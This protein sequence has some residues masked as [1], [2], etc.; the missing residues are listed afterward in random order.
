ME[1]RVEQLERSTEE[2]KHTVLAWS[3]MRIRAPGT[4]SREVAKVGARRRCM[5]SGTCTLSCGDLK[6]A[7]TRPWT[8]RCRLPIENWRG[9]RRR[10][11]CAR[12]AGG[13]CRRGAA[14]AKAMRCFQ[15]RPWM[16]RYRLPI[17]NWRVTRHRRPCARA[18]GRLCR[19]GAA[20]ARAR[21][22]EFFS[23]S[24]FNLWVAVVGN[25]LV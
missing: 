14:G 17:E 22:G 5:S 4:S 7:P 10:R 9:S 12:A 8:R 24:Y 11:S 1:N 21:C 2:R 23:N 3:R 15:T 25:Y 18:A 19:R 16:R 6:K 13:L 20:G